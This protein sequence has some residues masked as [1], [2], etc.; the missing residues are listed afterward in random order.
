M[1]AR[2]YILSS[3]VA[4]VV[5][6]ASTAQAVITITDDALAAPIDPLLFNSGNSSFT[7]I[8]DPASGSLR[9]RGQSFT[10]AGDPLSLGAITLQLRLD[11]AGNN[12]PTSGSNGLRL[13]LWEVGSSV[14][15]SDGISL[16]DEI[17]DFPTT[18]SAGEFFT[19]HLD[20]TV[21]L[22]ANTEYAFSVEWA[23]SAG[24]DIYLAQ[25]GGFGGSSDTLLFNNNASTLEVDSR[26]NGQD[27]TFFLQGAVDLGQNMTLEVN[28]TSGALRMLGPTS[29][30]QDVIYYQVD[31]ANGL[32]S[33]AAWYS[34]QDQDYEGSGPP[35]DG[36]GWE[37][38]GGS[39]ANAIGEAFLLGHS[40]MGIA[41]S[42][43]LG[44][45]FDVD[46]SFAAET[47]LSMS[48]RLTDGSLRQAQIVTFAGLLGDFDAD[49]DRDADDI[50]GLLQAVF[51]G[52][53]VPTF[54]M[55]RDGQVTKADADEWVFNAE[56]TFYGDANLDHAVTLVDLNAIGLNF[57]QTGGWAQGDFNGDQLI[58][59]VDLNTLGQ[60]FGQSATAS[61]VPEP[62]SLP[63]VIA[64]LAVITRRR[65]S[66]CGACR[67]RR[68]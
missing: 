57:G 66:R 8:S 63:L 25:S 9:I 43:D 30:N 37:E 58:T 45:V 35:G 67:S 23:T 41:T 18:M 15:P 68:A 49:S 64:V 48:Y 20:S 46:A 28:T 6:G 59:L 47:D 36:M 34:L 50:D 38:A 39:G 11:N 61:A 26:N 19:M 29:T 52:Q 3:F 42:L 51:T 55:T 22:S 21:A 24:Y 14:A 16:L 5:I 44:R 54:D 13:R 27:L 1:I 40:T 4:A 7:R 33:T 12:V 60:N 32:L 17:G 53:N 31:S 2:I 62:G 65:A 56:G 10:T